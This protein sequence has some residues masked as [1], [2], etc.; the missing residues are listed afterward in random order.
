MKLY[1]CVN[2]QPLN[3]Y[4]NFNLASDRIDF[5]N[6][7]TICEQSS[8]T[9]IILDNVLSYI[10][11]QTI[12][13]VLQII[14]SRL[15]K[16]GKLIIRDYDAQEVIQKYNNGLLSIADLNLVLF[17]NNAPSKTSCISH[18][19]LHDIITNTGLQIVSIE[20]LDLTFSLIAQRI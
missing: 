15:R 18:V 3:G 12:P 5:Q 20:L 9:E 1:I 19:H 2:Q 16:G 7:N 10:N 8:C 14:I 13:Q 11:L 17:G 6:P 4:K